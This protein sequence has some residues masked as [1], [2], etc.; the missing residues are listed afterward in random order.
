MCLLHS[1]W[2]EWAELKYSGHKSDLASLCLLL[3]WRMS[4]AKKLNLLHHHKDIYDK[5]NS[6]VLFLKVKILILVSH[7]LVLY[8]CGSIYINGLSH[9]FLDV[10]GHRTHFNETKHRVA[11]IIEKVLRHWDSSATK[12]KFSLCKLNMGILQWVRAEAWK[13]STEWWERL[14]QYGQKHAVYARPWT[15]LLCLTG[16]M[17]E[18]RV[19][20]DYSV[21]AHDI[22]DKAMLNTRLTLRERMTHLWG[23]FSPW[24]RD[25]SGKLL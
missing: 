19:S 21:H 12:V 1:A 25:C 6:D 2:E 4:T 23:L 24:T 5:C 17:G 15:E 11:G 16:E 20:L 8:Q 9:C 7:A 10:H 13:S 3:L 14:K 18:Q 22:K